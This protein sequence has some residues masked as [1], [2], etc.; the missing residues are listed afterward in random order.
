MAT[1]T[2]RHLYITAHARELSAI[3]DDEIFTDEHKT[4]LFWE[5]LD[6]MHKGT[7]RKVEKERLRQVEKALVLVAQ[8]GGATCIVILSC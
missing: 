3:D 1:A 5:G 8:L 4:N 7:V 6:K 2:S